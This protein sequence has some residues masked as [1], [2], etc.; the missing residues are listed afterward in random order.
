MPKLEL[1][2]TNPGTIAE[3]LARWR[4]STPIEMDRPVETAPE[5]GTSLTFGDVAHLIRR[6]SAALA[7]VGVRDGQRVVICKQNHV[8][9]LSWAYGAARIGAVPVLLSCANRP[10]D[11]AVLLDRIG[12][13]VVVTDDRTMAEGALA[14][15]LSPHATELLNLDGDGVGTA[16]LP[17]LDSPV[18]DPVPQG[19]DDVCIVTHTS[20]T[21]GV[22]KLVEFSVSQGGSTVMTQIRASSYGFTR[23]DRIA[24]SSS[25]VHARCIGGS[26]SALYAGLPLLI[27]SRP[28]EP[29]A[30]EALARFR[31]TILE[32]LPNEFLA[33]E[34]LARDPRRPLARVR[35]FHNT[36]D[37]IHPRSVRTLLDASDRRFPV[38]MQSWGQSESGAITMQ[39]F[40]RRSVRRRGEQTTRRV[41]WS[42]PPVTHVKVVD[43]T[44]KKRVR[45]GRP[46]VLMVSTPAMSKSYLGLADLHAHRRRGRWWTMGDVGRRTWSGAVELLDRQ[47]DSIEG[48]GSCIEVEDRLLDRLTDA[49]EV[50]IVKQADGRPAAVVNTAGDR[51][52]D[53]EDWRRAT[54]DLPE[55]G[56]PLH[57]PWDA[58]P[59]TATMKVRRRALAAAVDEPR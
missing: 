39:V 12:E 4:R 58:V 49:T 16:A 5:L 7:A 14:L 28:L 25:F 54:A 10:E 48:I 59:R 55:I 3:S 57:L 6:C 18:P 31:P 44:T 29:A 36:F 38:W 32:A 24:A 11:M 27:L 37:A 34:D 50:V 47:V 46:G 53:P 8:D 51:P 42:L 35:A 13:A 20:G 40:T 45:P 26:L 56:A 23:R 19:A 21:T 30:V 2:D 17:L 15:D 9:V 52:L 41:G 22:P 1:D 43:P 33:L